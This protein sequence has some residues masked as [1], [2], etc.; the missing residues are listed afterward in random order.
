MSQGYIL[1]EGECACDWQSRATPGQGAK[2]TSHCGPIAKVVP[3]PSQPVDTCPVVSVSHTSLIKDQTFSMS[4][5]HKD[6]SMVPI[7]LLFR[8]S[9]TCGPLPG[10]VSLLTMFPP[11][12]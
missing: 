12:K 8:V 11:E 2:Q 4:A 9:S 6:R 7:Y 3:K 5:G 10:S 1:W